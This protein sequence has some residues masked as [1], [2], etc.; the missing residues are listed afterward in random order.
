MGDQRRHMR[1]YMAYTPCSGD[2]REYIVESGVYISIARE[3][4][5]ESGVYSTAGEY[6]AESGVYSTTR[7]YITESGVFIWQFI[8]AA[9]RNGI[10][11]VLQWNGQFPPVLTIAY[12]RVL[13]STIETCIHEHNC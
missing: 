8:T 9:Q 3:Y 12:R 13:A 4:I 11:F 10:F 5:A 2:C 6:I 1:S 7:E